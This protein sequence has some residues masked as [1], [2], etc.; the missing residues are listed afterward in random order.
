MIARVLF[1]PAAK[2]LL[3]FLERDKADRS[4]QV[5]L[6]S[7]ATALLACAALYLILTQDPYSQWLKLALVALLLLSALGGEVLRRLGSATGARQVLDSVLDLPVY[8][9]VLHTLPSAIYQPQLPWLGAREYLGLFLVLLAGWLL[10]QHFGGAA[11]WLS[12]R[13]ERLLLF[14]LFVLAG[15][16]TTFEMVL[17]LGIV[18]LTL[19]LHLSLMAGRLRRMRLRLPRLPLGVL[20]GFLLR[21]GRV[22]ISAAVAVPGAL[23]ALLGRM[24]PPPRE[25]VAEEEPPEEPYR[26]HRFTAMVTDDAGNPIQGARVVLRNRDTGLEEVRISDGSGR[27]VFEGLVPGEYD[28][29][30][31]G[32]GIS[33]EEHRRYISMDQGEVFSIRLRSSDLSVVVSR[34]ELGTPVRDALVAV[35][36]EN[37]RR[38]AKTNNLGVAYFDALE[39]G[40]YLLEVRAE[41]FRRYSR[42]VSLFAENVVAVALE[43]L[44]E[45]VKEAEAAAEAKAGEGTRAEASPEG[46]AEEGEEQ[47]AP[48]EE[49]VIFGE[50]ALIEYTSDTRL[51]DVVSGIVREH[52][53]N[54]RDVFLVSMQPRTSR[55]REMFANFIE[56]GRVRV[57]NLATKGGPPERDS[58]IEE[59]PISS[60]EYFSAVFEEMPAGALFIFEPLSSVIVTLGAEQAYRFV[61]RTAEHLSNEGLF[62]ICFVNREMHS[63]RE[64]SS[65]RDLFMNVAEIAGGRI[66]K[67]R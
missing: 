24:R 64:L 63:T 14:S 50:S 15:A 26:G 7:A 5:L 22:C 55:Y 65:F 11:G 57:I 12:S 58:G 16:Y 44:E 41:G 37:F 39:M 30:I 9:T 43:P 35:S 51:E 34:R 2:V 18:V 33:P 25:E 59:V 45:S 40:E 53:E 46:G 19:L 54:D 52:L 49:E 21:L 42:P 47:L 62:F 27:C 67:V 3:Y 31:D 38:E 36:R 61:S 8:F 6:F 60:L 13:A 20:R 29:I 23:A 28:V 10:H 1:A 48:E 56:A 66:R 4:A 32:E 17:L